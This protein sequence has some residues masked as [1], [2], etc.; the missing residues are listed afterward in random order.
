MTAVVAA[1]ENRW[2]IDMGGGADPQGLLETCFN[3]GI[4]LRSFQFVEPTLH[5]VFLNLVGPEAREASFR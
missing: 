1:A 4:R 5:D 2:E 3:R